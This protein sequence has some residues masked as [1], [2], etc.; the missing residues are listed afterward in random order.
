MKNKTAPIVRAWRSET[1]RK[2]AWAIALASFALIVI[3]GSLVREEERS[4]RNETL[5]KTAATLASTTLSGGTET[6]DILLKVNDLLNVDAVSG[7]R[8]IQGADIPLSVG[9]THSDFPSA[10]TT[11]NVISLWTEDQS[12]VDVALKLEASLPYDWIVLRLDAMTQMPPSLLGSLINW[13]AAPIIALL[14]AIVC[15]WITG[16]YFLRPMAELQTY[17]QDNSGKYALSAVPSHLC[18][19]K[20]ESGIIAQQIENMRF[21][22]NEA[23]AKVDFQA[24]FLHETPYPL[25]RC[26]V[27]RKVLYANVAARAEA[28]LF[29]DETKEFVSPALSELVRKAFYDTKQV[30]GE[31]RCPD[32]IIVFR[33]IPVLDAGYVNLYGEV[34]KKTDPNL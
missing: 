34:S 28:S 4:L 26:S 17:L 5:I 25:V 8:L 12:S 9:E 11:Q 30:H 33:A 6:D 29:G 20:N 21:E 23:K 19:Q 32:H 18:A 1:G 13:V 15:L 10:N 2:F 27:N 16:L 14:N 31:I 3:L 7:V 22:V 24:R